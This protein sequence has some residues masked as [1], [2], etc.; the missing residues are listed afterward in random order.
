MKKIL[1]AILLMA[2]MVGC[3]KQEDCKEGCVPRRAANINMGVEPTPAPEPAPNP[4][5]KPKMEKKKQVV[6]Y[7]FWAPWCAPC[8]R[9]GPVFDGWSKKYSS[10]NVKF[11]KVNADEQP[12]ILK[13]YDVSALPTVIVEVDGKVVAKFEGAPKEEQIVAHLPK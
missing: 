2:F 3:V 11:I 5:E 1:F 10:E 4:Q 9:F 8:R 12:A 7:D 13:K 6:V